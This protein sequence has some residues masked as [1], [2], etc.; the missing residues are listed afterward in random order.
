M[1][2][3]VDQYLSLI[4]RL[5][6]FASNVV[7]DMESMGD[8]G[9]IDDTALLSSPSRITQTTLSLKDFHRCSITHSLTNIQSSD[10]GSIKGQAISLPFPQA[11]RPDSLV[12]MAVV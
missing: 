12:A 5:G 10:L 9:I 3:N 6:I 8:L 2:L 11:L 1:R 7:E 4:S